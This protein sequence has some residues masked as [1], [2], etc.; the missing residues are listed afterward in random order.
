MLCTRELT[1]CCSQLYFKNKHAHRKRDRICPYWRYAE[2]CWEGNWKNL[3][4]GYKLPEHHPAGSGGRPLP[5]N[6]DLEGALGRNT[7]SA[8]VTGPPAPRARNTG[9]RS[10]SLAPAAGP[11]ARVQALPPVHGLAGDMHSCRRSERSRRAGA[12]C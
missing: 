4:K 1:D 3:V 9:G 5:P 8:P 10:A 2:G 6:T 12:C 11:P 7:L